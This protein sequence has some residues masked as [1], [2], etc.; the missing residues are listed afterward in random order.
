MPSM[1]P[2]ENPDPRD[3]IGEAYR[4]EGLSPDECRSIFLDWL[5]GLPAGTDTAAMARILLG[6]HM[7]AGEGHPM[8]AILRE[9]AVETGQA[10]VRRGGRRGRLG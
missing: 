10:A 6:R 7:P 5:L 2:A 8:T 3:L 9:A 1:D 4:M